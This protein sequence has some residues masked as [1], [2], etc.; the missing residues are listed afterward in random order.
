MTTHQILIVT[1]KA[2]ANPAFA[3][4]QEAYE[5]D[6]RRQPLYHD[7]TFRPSWALL[8]R[9]AQDSWNR[10]PTLPQLV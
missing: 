4:G 8:W 1:G 10:N 9:V 2:Q 3:T 5:A 6:L 7:G